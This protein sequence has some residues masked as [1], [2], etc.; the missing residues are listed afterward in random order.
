MKKLFL[1][2]II[3]TIGTSLLAQN[4]I[5]PQ[6]KSDTLGTIGKIISHWKN[7]EMEFW[8]FDNYLY[9]IEYTDGTIAQGTWD[10][11]G[12]KLTLHK[13]KL[14]S[15]SAKEYQIP[16]MTEEEFEKK[17]G[18]KVFTIPTNQDMH[19]DPYPLIAK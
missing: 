8:L 3:C 18:I 4:P 17:F 16:M 11:D 14:H 15:T 10:F 9:R 6:K 13:D 2:F 7:V 12:G 5:Y 1:F 19:L